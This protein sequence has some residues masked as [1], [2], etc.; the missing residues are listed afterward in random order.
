MCSVTKPTR[1]VANDE[2]GFGLLSLTTVHRT[3]SLLTGHFSSLVGV[4]NMSARDWD[5][6]LWQR[7]SDLLQ[8]AERIQRNFLQIAAGAHYRASHGRI[9][10]WEPAVNVVGTDE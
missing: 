1:I 3:P 6:L 10:C 7:A 9:S 4:D 5:F 2:E 8:Q